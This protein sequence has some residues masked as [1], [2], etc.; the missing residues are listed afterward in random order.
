MILNK[1]HIILFFT[2][3]FLFTF[4]NAQNIELDTK[5][6]TFNI[7]GI[8]LYDSTEFISNSIHGFT[9][10]SVFD[11][12]NSDEVWWT[13]NSKCI[14]G[15]FEIDT[16]KNNYLIFKWNKDQTECDWVGIGFGWDGWSAKDMAYLKDSLAF[17]ISLRSSKREIT[18]LPWAFGIEDYNGNQCWVGFKK[19]FLS[20]SIIGRTWNSILI[21]LSAFPIIE[22]EVDLTAT[23]QLIIQLF[24]AGEIELKSIR[25]VSF[26]KEMKH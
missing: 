12:S 11:G 21:P 25:L 10:L 26:K 23:K 19:E 22:N 16:L 15:K 8:G 7:K 14:Q 3:S 17:E 4:L 6:K 9:Q 24:A 20:K 2:F 18:N 1:I 13:K 5:I